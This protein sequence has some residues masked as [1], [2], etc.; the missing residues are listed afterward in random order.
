MILKSGGQTPAAYEA[1]SDEPEYERLNAALVDLLDATPCMRIID[2]GCGTGSLASICIER[3]GA[4]M[5]CV[6]PDHEMLQSVTNRLGPRVGTIRADGETFAD[7]FPEASV[8]AVLFGN[9]IHLVTDITAALVGSVKVLAPGGVLAFN[10]SFFT[11]AEEPAERHWYRKAVLRARQ[12]LPNDQRPAHR[13]P[14]V[15]AKRPASEARYREEL[16]GAGFTE[17]TSS[18]ST[19]TM[20]RDLVVKIVQAPV[21]AGGALPGVDAAAAA[22]ALVRATDEIFDQ[23]PELTLTRR[24]LYMSARKPGES[25]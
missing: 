24:W 13:S 23:H 10:T 12:L 25:S 19:L 8:D 21:F 22:E 9:C 1:V 14:R 20:T 3:F 16:E 18:Y 15:P 11:G 6:D 5:W 2:V 4:L 17:V 7:A